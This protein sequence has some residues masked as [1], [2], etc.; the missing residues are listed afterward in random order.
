MAITDLKVRDLMTDQVFSVTES[1]DLETASELMDSIQV[2]HL[3]VID[4]EGMLVGI[5]SQ[6]DLIREGR[7]RAEELTL[8]GERQLLRTTRVGAVMTKD[9]TTVGADEDIVEAGQ[10]MLENKI[11]C[12][13]VVEGDRLMGILTESDFVRFL[14]RNAMEEEDVAGATPSVQRPSDRYDQSASRYG[15]DTVLGSS[16]LGQGSGLTGEGGVPS[17]MA[18]TEGSQTG[19]A[20]NSAAS[21]G[22]QGTDDATSTAPSDTESLDD[23]E[24]RQAG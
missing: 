4:E 23:L 24:E 16:P 2:R 8:E 13:P 12:L 1:D 9:A 18:G 20:D 5:L 15:R 11:S 22:W 3:P 21:G 14:I 10:T 17:G 7:F 6:T 19:E